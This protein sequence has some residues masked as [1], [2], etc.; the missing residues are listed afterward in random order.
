MIQ[1]A[2]VFSLKSGHP[3]RTNPSGV[4]MLETPDRQQFTIDS[5]LGSTGDLSVDEPAE[6]MPSAQTASNAIKILFM[7]FPPLPYVLRYALV[8]AVALPFFNPKHME[9]YRHRATILGRERPFM[10]CCPWPQPVWSLPASGQGN[11]SKHQADLD[12][13]FLNV[14]LASAFFAILLTRVLDGL[15]LSRIRENLLISLFRA[16][17]K[18]HASLVRWGT[19]RSTI[20]AVAISISYAL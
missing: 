10:A 8:C 11:G 19:W 16:R 6:A 7:T 2:Q 1:V 4:E 5:G 13:I 3:P 17:K 14:V 9:T 12:G 18:S 20:P 15:C